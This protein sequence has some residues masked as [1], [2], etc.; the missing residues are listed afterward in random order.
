MKMHVLSGGRLRMK[1]HIFLPDSPREETIDLP[2]SCFLFRHEQ[3]N[4][5][6]DTGCHTQVAVEPEARWGSLSKAMVPTMAPN[7]NVVSELAR[8]NLAPADIDLVVN[9][10]LHCDHCGCN[11]FFD[12][13]TV[14]VHEAELKTAQDSDNEG[15][16]YFR[17]DWDNDLP[18]VAIERETDLFDDGRLVLLPLPGHSPGLIGLLASLAKSGCFLLASDAVA[19]RDNLD[20]EIMPKNTWNKDL[21]AKSVGEI[22]KIERSGVSVLCGHDLGQWT[23]FKPAEA[24]YE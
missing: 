21:A 10:H 16:G 5:L 7:E 6:F 12:N 8:V 1:K 17:A 4:V 2:V 3:G 22:K 11:S 14:Y 13:A 15:K 23:A 19:V 20:R 24:A 18:I 9:S